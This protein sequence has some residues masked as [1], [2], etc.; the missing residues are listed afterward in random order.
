MTR[1][2]READHPAH[3]QHLPIQ[4][5]ARKTRAAILSASATQFDTL[6]YAE[7][8]IS[9]IIGASGITKGAIYFH[10][11]SKEAIALRLID[12]WNH[13]D[14]ETISI[15]RILGSQSVTKSRILGTESTKLGQLTAIFASL[16]DRVATDPAL[17]AGMKLTFELSIDDDH[18]FSRWVEDIHS[19]VDE[20]I[21]AGELGNHPAAHRLAWN[22]CTGTVGAAHAH[23]TT[24]QHTE[25]VTH[26]DDTVAAHL[27]AAQR[28]SSHA[29]R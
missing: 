13:T 5:R 4:A 23:T 24:P 15:T 2:L 25:L 9:T 28:R 18:A 22:L 26:I 1:T 10:F 3:G 14:G 12:D 6:G 27:I 17:R 21:T 11:K 29:T 8:S 7:T 16:A 20:A 19:L